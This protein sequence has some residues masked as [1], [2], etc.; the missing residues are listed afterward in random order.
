MPK[1][2][3]VKAMS[4]G[5]PQIII[6]CSS[7]FGPS[8]CRKGRRLPVVEFGENRPEPG[9]AHGHLWITATSEFSVG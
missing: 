4:P 7:T 5:R 9:T 6:K 1:N 2:S 8:A 3:R